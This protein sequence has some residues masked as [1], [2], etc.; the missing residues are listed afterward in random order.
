MSNHKEAFDAN[1]VINAEFGYLLMDDILVNLK[2]IC[3]C[4]LELDITKNM[5][6]FNDHCYNKS[7]FEQ[8]KSLSLREY[9]HKE[10]E[11]VGL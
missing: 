4:P 11:Y 5:C 8:L 6:M 2:G 10:N 3:K 1:R 7:R 9:N